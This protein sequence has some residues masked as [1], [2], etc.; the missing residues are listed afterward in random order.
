MKK[1]VVALTAGAMLL[2]TFFYVIASRT[3]WVDV[4][5]PMPP[6]GEAAENPFYA[7]ERFVEALGGRSVR[8]RQFT[9]PDRQAVIVLAAWH[10]DLTENRRYSLERWVES[11]GRLVVAGPLSGGTAEFGRWSGVRRRQRLPPVPDGDAEM[12][13]RPVR[14]EAGATGSAQPDRPRLLCDLDSAAVLD[15]PR[16]ASWLLRDQVGIQAVRVAVG[17]GSVTVI[18]GTPFQ[19]RQL[20]EADH[21]W[22]FAAAT[23]LRRGDEVHFLTEDD[24]P[25]MLG[26]VWRHGAP[27]VVLALA[28]IGLALWRNGARFGPLGEPHESGRRSLA[29]QIRGTGQFA[30]R[31]GDGESL[32]EAAVRA[33]SEAANRRIPG[34]ARL[35]PADRAA[36]LARV[37]GFDRDAFSAAVHH[38]GLRSAASLRGTLAF[39]ET[40]RREIL[41]DPRRERSAGP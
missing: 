23:Q 24:H 10:W 6:R 8:D 28:A 13:C 2:S 30:L 39:I 31:Y 12:P 32:H 33:L 35:S 3:E 5:V 7:A 38:A 9:V 26:L 36:A 21:G 25:S 40:A 19:F 18:N 34:Y 1:T 15:T 37:T 27:V 4:T 22:L 29:E 16:R 11:G 14:E 20:L 41:R 17:S